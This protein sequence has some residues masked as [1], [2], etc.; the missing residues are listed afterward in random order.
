MSW[1]FACNADVNGH[2]PTFEL[3]NIGTIEQNADQS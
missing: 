2:L 3:E 1:H